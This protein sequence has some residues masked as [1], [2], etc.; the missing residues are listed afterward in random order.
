MN[1]YYLREGFSLL[2]PQHKIKFDEKM[3]QKSDG[4]RGRCAFGC[5]GEPCLSRGVC[6]GYAVQ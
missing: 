3:K 1:N 4:M 2:S 6:P 5:G